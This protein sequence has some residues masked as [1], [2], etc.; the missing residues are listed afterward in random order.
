MAMTKVLVVKKQ[1]AC[2][3]NRIDDNC[4]HERGNVDDCDDNDR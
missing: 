2:G 3:R 1:G 4:C